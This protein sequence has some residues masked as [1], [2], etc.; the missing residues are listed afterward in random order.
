MFVRCSQ[1][2]QEETFAK[3]SFLIKL[4]ASGLNFA[5]LFKKTYLL[6]TNI[7]HELRILTGKKH[8]QIKL[9]R[10]LKVRIWAF[11]LL[12]Q[13]K[14]LLEVLKLKQNFQKNKLGTGKTPFFVLGPFYSHHSICLNIGFWYGS[15]VW[16]W[17]A[18]NLSAFN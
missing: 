5:K 8:G 14:S 18:F 4:Q 13:I 6:L 16:K 9:Q 15:F 3:V 2:S 10:L 7:K 11:G 12:H 1:N 17:C